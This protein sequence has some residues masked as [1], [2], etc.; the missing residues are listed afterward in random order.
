VSD[1]DSSIEFYE[2][3]CKLTIVRDRRKESEGSGTVWLGPKPREGNLPTF[4]LVLMQG[5][6]A[7]RIDHLGFQC[8]SRD[9]VDEIAR[10]AAREG[11][12]VY[13]PEDSGGTVGYWTMI[14]DPD[15]HLVEFTFG[16][17]IAGLN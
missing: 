14:R 6:V 5:E 16:Q 4:V 17:P 1:F 10:E 3:Y 7:S 13:S 2:K 8:E 9:E 15:G 11:A 12:L